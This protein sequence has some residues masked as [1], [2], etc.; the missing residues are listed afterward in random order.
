M[1]TKTPRWVKILIAILIISNF[2]VWSLYNGERD[3]INEYRQQVKDQQWEISQLHRDI[4]TVECEREWLSDELVALGY[5]PVDLTKIKKTSMSNVLSDIM[6][7]PKFWSKRQDIDQ[8]LDTLL[9]GSGKISEYDISKMAVL[10]EW[11]AIDLTKLYW[12]ELK[13][14]GIIS[15]IAVGNLDLHGETLSESNHSW[16]LVFYKD[17]D[18][19]GWSK[20]S[21]LRTLIFEP[22]PRYSF[23]IHIDPEM[24]LQYSEGYFY[25]SPSELETDIGEE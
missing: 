23:V 7:N 5:R 6:G 15:V 11:D 14:N 17:W 18:K 12:Q 10:G 20:K 4:D 19:D 16:L 8:Y 1:E 22:T 25:T 3:Q 9:S 24:S 21:P 2:V 13:D